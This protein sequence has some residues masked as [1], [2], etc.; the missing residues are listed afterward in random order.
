MILAREL[1]LRVVAQSAEV[2]EVGILLDPSFAGFA[3]HFPGAPVLPGMCHIDLALRAA[4][5]LAG[6]PLGLATIERARFVRRVLPGEELRIRVT[7][8]A[9]EGGARIVSAEHLV[10]S[11][12]AASL[13]LR[14][15]ARA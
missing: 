6:A 11:E 10:G 13:R 14:V 2:A 5:L 9:G 4:S 15:L 3:G 1:V 8:G 7:L 12:P